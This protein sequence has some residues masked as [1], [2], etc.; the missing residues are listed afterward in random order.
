MGWLEHRSITTTA[1]GLNLQQIYGVGLGWTVIKTPVQEFDVK[2]D[3]HYET[4]ELPAANAE[5]RI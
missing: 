1:Q 4:A 2:A 3:V 5:Q